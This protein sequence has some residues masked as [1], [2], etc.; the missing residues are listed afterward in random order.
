MDLAEQPTALE[1]AG[2]RAPV[3]GNGG[4]CYRK[5]LTANAVR[6]SDPHARGCA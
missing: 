5:H 4:A 2:W 1:P 6:P 3:G